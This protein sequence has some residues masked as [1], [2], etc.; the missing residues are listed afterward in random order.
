MVG[1]RD[2][3]ASRS[4]RAGRCLRS[5][6]EPPGKPRFPNGPRGPPSDWAPGESRFEDLLG[7]PGQDGP[8]PTDV[9]PHGRRDARRI[10]KRLSPERGRRIRFGCTGWRRPMRAIAQPASVRNCRLA[11][12]R[13]PTCCGTEEGVLLLSFVTDGKSGL[14]GI[15]EPP[16]GFF[17]PKVDLWSTC[18]QPMREASVQPSAT[19][20]EGRFLHDHG[21]MAGKCV[22][23]EPGKACKRPTRS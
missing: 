6:A 12:L 17:A 18:P 15:L 11:P 1:S 7:G 16:T 13:N 8:A 10:A 3:L 9:W 2:R 21:P 19:T 14:Q 22:L 4:H 20:D 23:A 5:H